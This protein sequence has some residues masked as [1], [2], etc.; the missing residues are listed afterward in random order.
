MGE[1]H[2]ST[3]NALRSLGP[4]WRWPLAGDGNRPEPDTHSLDYVPASD[5]LMK[6]PTQ[7]FS[8]STVQSF[9]WLCS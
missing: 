1:D 8:P 5:A 2:V 9:V 4:G 7:T 6:F 3:Q